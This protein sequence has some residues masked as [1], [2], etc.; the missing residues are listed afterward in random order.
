MPTKA[1]V[2][3]KKRPLSLELSIRDFK[4]GSP[5]E[6][7]PIWPLLAGVVPVADSEVPRVEPVE[8][9]LPALDDGDADDFSNL[10]R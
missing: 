10:G 9:R 2:S 7:E 6:V 5:C 4:E 8:R 3:K 1:H